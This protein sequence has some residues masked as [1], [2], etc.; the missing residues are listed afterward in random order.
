MYIFILHI[1]KAKQ[2]TKTEIKKDFYVSWTQHE[3][4]LSFLNSKCDQIVSRRIN[5]EATETQ[6]F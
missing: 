5:P 2:N 4:V 1:K 3:E 6:R